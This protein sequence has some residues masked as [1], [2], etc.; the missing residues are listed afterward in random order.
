[1]DN[2]IILR[3]VDLKKYFPVRRNIRELIRPSFVRAVDGVSIEI[4]KGEFFGL[5]GESGCGKT[6]LGK[7]IVKIIQPT[8]G[9]IIFNGEDITYK[10][11]SGET[12]RKIQMIFQNPFS[13]LNPKMKV[14]DLILEGIIIH[15]LYPRKKFAEKLEELLNAVGLGIEFAE[16]FPD[17]LSGGQRQRVVIARAIA[18]EPEILVADE[19]TS[20]LDVSVRAQIIELFEKIRKNMNLSI[21][22][23]SHD[24]HTVKVY[25]E[26]VAVMYLGEIVEIGPKEKIFSNPL[27]PYTYILLNSVIDLERVKNEGRYNIGFDSLGEAPSPL[28]EIRGCKFASRCPFKDKICEE[29]KPELIELNGREV[30]CHFAGKIKFEGN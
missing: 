7:L 13:S 27:H 4:K 15:K 11:I 9:K 29:K 17:E 28:D 26:R 5:V 1:M 21:I 6:T 30:S 8:S 22:F 14:K 3:T 12:R 25:A 10:R 16:R 18:V 23:I 20:S 24:I 19:P 2:N